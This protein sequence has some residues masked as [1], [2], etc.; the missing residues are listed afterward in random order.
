MK[1]R[2]RPQDAVFHEKILDTFGSNFS[3]HAKG[4]GEWLKNSVD[5]YIR[6]NISD[7]NQNIILN[8]S[9]KNNKLERIECIDFVGT[10]FK[11][12]E[13]SLKVWGNPDAASKGRE[14]KVYG[15]HGNGGKFYMRQMFESSYFITYRDDR[16]TVFGFNKEKKYGYDEK[17]KDTKVSFK[18]A[19]KIAEIP[20]H[21]LKR[22]I[23]K[24]IFL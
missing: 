9:K 21:I 24:I 17:Y 22:R 20:E 11:D 23:K 6:E 8:F 4:I 16:I 10:T 3:D 19:I 15:G 13:E 18:E 7:E 5:A 12:I 1:I 14:F 2:I